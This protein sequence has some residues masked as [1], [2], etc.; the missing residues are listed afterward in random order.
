MIVTKKIQRDQIQSFDQLRQYLID[1]M[2]Y[3]DLLIFASMPTVVQQF[4]QNYGLD[5]HRNRFYMFIRVDKPKFF[6]TIAQ[7][8]PKKNELH[9]VIYPDHILALQLVSTNET[10]C[11][12]AKTLIDDVPYTAG[13]IADEVL[14]ILKT[15]RITDR[16]IVDYLHEISL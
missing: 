4:I 3:G 14:A 12:T 15:H 7:D 9:D 2:V 8:L 13:V 1:K 6:A 16:N 5:V 11:I 10:V